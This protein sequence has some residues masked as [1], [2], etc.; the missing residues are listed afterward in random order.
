[1]SG[2]HY[3]M[4]QELDEKMK[5]LMSRVK[6]GD[7]D[8]VIAEAVLLLD[9]TDPAFEEYR[10]AFNVIIARAFYNKSDFPSAVTYYKKIA[11]APDADHK[12]W[13]ELASVYV[14]AGDIPEALAA[15][16]TAGEKCPNSAE[17]LGATLSFMMALAASKHFPEA[18]VLLN[19]LKEFYL[20][21]P[22]LDSTYLITAT[23]GFPPML[24]DFL[25]QA[26]PVLDHMS[27]DDRGAWIRDLER[28][29]HEEDKHLVKELR[30]QVDH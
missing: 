20:K 30:E 24:E 12:S 6:N 3:F 18:E 9:S 28:R 4:S 1:M 29:L 2:I 14:K 16:R 23:G 10:T 19:Q 17:D 7:N 27:K 11:E 13:L 5:E 15:Y 21:L 22:T 26:R 25:E 8:R